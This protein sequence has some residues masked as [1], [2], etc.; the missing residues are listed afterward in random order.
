MNLKTKNRIWKPKIKIQELY[1]WSSD[2]KLRGKFISDFPILIL[3]FSIL[4]L[5]FS[6][7][8]SQSSSKWRF[9]QTKSFSIT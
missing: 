9:E 1:I 7:Y 5:H 6:N 8:L 2:M 4:S 3:V